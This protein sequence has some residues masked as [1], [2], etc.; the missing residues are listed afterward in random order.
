MHYLLLCILANVGIF[1]C[2]RQF[3]AF[4][5]DTFQAIVFNY[6]TCVAT[7]IIFMG[8]SEALTEINYTQP[9]V[10]I[11]IV[12]GLIFISTFYLMALTTQRFSMTVSSIASKMSLIIPVIISLLV[13]KVQSKEYTVFNYLGMFMAFPAI[14]MSSFKKR[15]VEGSDFAGFAILLP[16][17]VFVLGG[18]IDS[19][20]NYTSYHYLTEAVEPV[21]PI[22][23]FSS[24]AFIGIISIMISGRKITK[25]NVLG[26]AILGA[27]NYFSI[28]FLIRTLSYFK[29]DG[30]VVYPML[31][32]GIILL[33][34]FISIL[35]FK[36]RLSKLNQSGLLLA[37]LSIILLS[38]EELMSL[39]F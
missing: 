19:S 22:V 37:I 15:G 34:A 7:G 31:N 1:L 21:F 3:K 24:A 25:G 27:I 11:G 35:V 33:S 28:Y 18:L 30:A 39:A 20:I 17:S 4:G 36:E 14:L 16:I 26:G 5:L 2:F 8:K 10:I 12:L 32:V 38:F 13:L 23:I 29:N 9:W 6:I